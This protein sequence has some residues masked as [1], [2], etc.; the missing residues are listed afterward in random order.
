MCTNCYDYSV[1]ISARAI[2]VAG[3]ATKLGSEQTIIFLNQLT[4]ISEIT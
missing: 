4:M 2:L 3:H 1:K